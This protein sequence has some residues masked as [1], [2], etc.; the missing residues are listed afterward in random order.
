MNPVNAPMFQAVCEVHHTS[1][2]AI[3]VITLNLLPLNTTSS[4]WEKEDTQH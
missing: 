2:L 3:M 4:F 1:L